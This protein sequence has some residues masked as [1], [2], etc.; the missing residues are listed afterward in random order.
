MVPVVVVVFV[1]FFAPVA[2]D[3]LTIVVP[4]DAL[5]ITVL[6]LFSRLCPR[7][8]GRD[9]GLRAVPVVVFPAGAT[10]SC[11]IVFREAVVAPLLVL[12]GLVSFSGEGRLDINCSCWIFEGDFRGDWGNVREFDDFGERTRDSESSDTARFETARDEPARLGLVRFL[13]F[14]SGG[15]P[16]STNGA[17]SLSDEWISSLDLV[18]T[19]LKQTSRIP[20]HTSSV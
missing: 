19:C 11:A 12:R 4:F 10:F 2:F 7:V 17:F 14:A 20:I 13:G 5:D 1:V 6:L 3:G 16:S 8:G 15:C 18:R 9:G